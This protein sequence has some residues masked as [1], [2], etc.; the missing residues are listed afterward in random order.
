MTSG[1]WAERTALARG[2]RGD[3]EFVE[4]ATASAAGLRH[5]AYLLTGDG[6]AA[7]EAVQTALVRT[8]AAWPRVRRDDAFAYA[9]RTLVN[10]LTDRWRRKLKEYP[11]EDL[12]EPRVGSDIADEVAL[13]QWVTGALATLTARERAVIVLRYLFD[14]PEATVA[15]DLGI[16][17]GTVK[18]TSARAVRAALAAGQGFRRVAGA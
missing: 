18:S 1:E 13:R 2:S 6:H 12:P 5:A 15:R 3:E 14:L 11:V 10:H 16:T 17:A 4:F 9:R 8:Y 7:E